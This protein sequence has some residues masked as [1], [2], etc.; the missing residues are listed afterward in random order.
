MQG[1]ISSLYTI[2]FIKY[3]PIFMFDLPNDNFL[4]QSK[5]SIALALGLIFFSIILI[6]RY[7]DKK[8][9]NI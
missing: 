2:L 4:L 8:T 1:A 9:K 6:F 3:V 5:L 7:Y